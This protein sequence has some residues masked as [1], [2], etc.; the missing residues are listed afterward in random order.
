M[1]LIPQHKPEPYNVPESEQLLARLEPLVLPGFISKDV[2]SEIIKSNAPKKRSTNK[3]HAKGYTNRTDQRVLS[4]DLSLLTPL[5]S[6]KTVEK[7]INEYWGVNRK[8]C[9]LSDGTDP[10][11]YTVYY[12]GQQCNEHMDIVINDGV[13]MRPKRR[14]TALVY[15]SSWTHIEQPSDSLELFTGGEL[16]FTSLLDEHDNYVTYMP[17]AGDV[18]LFP[19]THHYKHGVLPVTSGQR[20][21]VVMFLEFDDD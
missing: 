13:L 6:P 10:F 12:P 19:T 5:F 14:V 18:I 9:H 11:I 1:R 21:T 8:Y 7:H 3:A 17:Q 15:L 2:C 4:S 20:H 16:I